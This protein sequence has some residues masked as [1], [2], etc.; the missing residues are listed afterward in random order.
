MTFAGRDYELELLRKEGESSYASLIVIM[1]RRRIGKTRLV[2]EAFK[3]NLWIFE[4]LEDEPENVQLQK[5]MDDLSFNVSEQSYKFMSVKNWTDALHIL[6]LAWEK[7][8]K[9]V[10]FFDEV[11]WLANFDKSFATRFKSSWERYWSL[12]KQSLFILCGSVAT[13]INNEI[14][15]SKALYQRI[16][17]VINLQPLS[18]KE[19]KRLCGKKRH[20]L[21][22]LDL[23]MSVGGVPKYVEYFDLNKSVTINLNELFFSKDGKLVSEFDSLFHS[24]FQNQKTYKE[25]VR[26]L[27][28]KPGLT[29]KEIS[30]IGDLSMSS[31][32]MLSHLLESLCLNGFVEKFQSLD[33]KPNTNI[34]K[35]RVA[36]E[37]LNFYFK[38]VRP[39]LNRIKKNTK[40]K[41]LLQEIAIG[42]SYEKWRGLAYERLCYKHHDVLADKLG[43]GSVIYQA[44]SFFKRQTKKRKGFQIDL[45]FLR[46]DRVV[47]LCEIKY[48]KNKIS[49]AI[50]PS[51]KQKIDLIQ[52]YF[53]NKAIEPVLITTLGATKDLEKTK[54]FREVLTAKDLF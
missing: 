30:E 41:N 1:G 32:G 31:G 54:F 43:F 35:Y 13:F 48:S 37:Y 4:G 28:D 50:V 53:P 29:N 8:G 39:N 44:G 25:I 14:I 6:Y 24:H 36:D 47:T 5:F 33:A 46:E 9:P 7:F 16:T 23:Y 51:V 38:F 26:V 3:K 27:Y 12:D 2:K 20:Y 10:I 49:E 52:G 11:Q 34:F 21:E 19:I 18:L 15:K 42:S 45:I 17:T 22:V 40:N